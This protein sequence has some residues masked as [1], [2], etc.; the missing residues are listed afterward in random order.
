MRTLH[1]A[2][3][4]DGITIRLIERETKPHFVIT[5]STH[6]FGRFVPLEE[7]GNDRACAVDIFVR[8]VERIIGGAK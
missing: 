3:T 8:H 4:P 6:N 2:R 1:H 7:V 5:A